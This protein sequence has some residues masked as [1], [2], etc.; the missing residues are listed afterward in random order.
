MK[1]GSTDDISSYLAKL[2]QAQGTSTSSTASTTSTLL[3]NL[4]YSDTVEISEDA[5]SYLAS[6]ST[7]AMQPP[8]PPP[9]DHADEALQSLVD[10][11]TITTEQA[12]AIKDAIIS[13]VEAE[14]TASS[15]D[16][17]EQTANSG[18]PLESILD[19]LISDGTL[20]EEQAASVADALKPPP[21]PPPP[22]AAATSDDSTTESQEVTDETSTSATGVTSSVLSEL[23]DSSSDLETDD[24]DTI[25]KRLM[26]YGSS[27]S[28]YVSTLI[29]ALGSDEDDPLQALYNNL[30]SKA[31]LTSDQISALE[32]EMMSQADTSESA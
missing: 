17:T 9:M 27:T 21:P 28:E 10:D 8:P 3:G 15:S 22:E 31:M 4:A 24:I 5:Y 26:T 25:L 23:L 11:G 12:S 29:G 7:S 32:T 30:K 16:S 14:E 13:A 19:S 20:S 6:E 18:N 1:I 2:Y